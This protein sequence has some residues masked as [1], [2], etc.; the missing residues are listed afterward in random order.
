MDRSSVKRRRS[1]FSGLRLLCAQAGIERILINGSFVTDR[2]EPNDVDC[3]LLHGPSYRA[4]SRK[5]GLL[6]RGLPFI[7][8]KIVKRDEY[9]F[10][11]NTIF[12]SDRDMMAKGVVEVVVA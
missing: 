9:D 12:A 11:A 3:M 10:F 2:V 1:R 6:R 7:E 5:A 4:R 8:L